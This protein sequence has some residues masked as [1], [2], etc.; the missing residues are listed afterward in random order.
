VFRHVRHLRGFLA[1]LVALAMTAGLALAAR[2]ATM[3]QAATDGLGT[4]AGAAGKVVP[5]VAEPTEAAPEAEE[6]PD[7][8]VEEPDEDAPT[9][10]EAADN[11]GAT[12]SA[13][14][15]GETPEGFDNHG[16][17]VKSV[18]TANHGQ[19]T[20]KAAR[21]AAAT[22]GSDAATNAKPNR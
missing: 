6:T 14:A 20:A 5:V 18:A 19:D 12:V 21:E 9:E 10:D 11:H 17:Y 7:A 3:P 22:K 2:P 13:A 4:A 8:T 16:Q 1:A 15:Q